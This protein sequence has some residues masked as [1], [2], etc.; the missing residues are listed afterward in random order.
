M[1]CLDVL[2]EFC[3]NSP[4]SQ[5]FPTTTVCDNHILVSNLPIPIYYLIY[6]FKI[7]LSH[8]IFFW[9][10]SWRPEAAQRCQLSLNFTMICELTRLW[11]SWNYHQALYVLGSTKSKLASMNLSSSSPRCCYWVTSSAKSFRFQISLVRNVGPVPH[12][13]GCCS[14]WSW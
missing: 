6:V 10:S 9:R 5:M 2:V 12:V 1:C 3:L 8:S 13:V 14:L 7:N 4:V 11:A